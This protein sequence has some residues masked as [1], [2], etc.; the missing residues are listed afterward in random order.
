MIKRLRLQFVV[1]TMVL[2]AVMLSIILGIICYTTYSRMENETSEALTLASKTVNRQEKPEKEKAPDSS[3]TDG[4][5][6]PTDGSREAHDDP[7]AMHEHPCFFLY[8]NE[9]GEI[10]AEGHPYYNLT[11]Q[12]KLADILREAIA[13]GKEEGILR[14]RDL[15]FLKKTAGG[16]TEYVFADIAGQRHTLRTLLVTC[17]LIFISAMAAFGCISWWLSKRF[18]RPVEIAWQQQRQFVA[19]ASHEPVSYT[20][21]TLPTMAVV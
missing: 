15:H 3:D 1:A 8:Y 16:R 13:T 20:H 18:V 9:A 10:V 5:E 17:I 7:D 11:D 21:L 19:D 12:E 14:G 4:P 2:M 6:T